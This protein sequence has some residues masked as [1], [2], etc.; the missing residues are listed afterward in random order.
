MNGAIDKPLEKPTASY[1]LCTV[2]Y[3]ACVRSAALF[4]AAVPPHR[5]ALIAE[6]V[7]CTG[8]QDGFYGVNRRSTMS[9]TFGRARFSNPT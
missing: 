4:L 6:T 9:V 7:Y 5:V 2:C 8:R 3:Y 1:V